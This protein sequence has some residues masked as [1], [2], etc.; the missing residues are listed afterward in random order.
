MGRAGSRSAIQKRRQGYLVTRRRYFGWRR[1]L[2][3]QHAWRP[4]GPGRWRSS[5]PLNSRT[6]ASGRRPDR[7]GQILKRRDQVGLAAETLRTAATVVFVV[8]AA[9]WTWQRADG[10]GATLAAAGFQ[11]RGR[12]ALAP[13]RRNLAPLGHR[14]AVGRSV[15]LLHLAG[16]AGAGRGALA[17][18]PG[19][20]FRRR[21]DGAAVRPAAVGRRRG[22]VRRG[23]PH[24]RQPGTPRR[25]CWRRTPGK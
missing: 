20:P 9:C 11:R 18:H 6:S 10:D 5:R 14:P 23:N 16:V 25:A 1:P 22:I 24:H 12:H 4:W 19:R 15:P 2:W 8:A 17:A 21:R 13:G 7:L 3:R